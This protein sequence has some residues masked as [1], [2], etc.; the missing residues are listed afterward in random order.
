MA[1]ASIDSSCEILNL[2]TAIFNSK[3][4]HQPIFLQ[5]HLDVNLDCLKCIRGRSTITMISALVVLKL[6]LTYC[7][8]LEVDECPNCCLTSNACQR[9]HCILQGLCIENI[10]LFLVGV[11][12]ATFLSNRAQKRYTNYQKHSIFVP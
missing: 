11:F 9:E 5:G 7:C 12:K 10:V 1:S 8:L 4:N 6:N 3:K 2:L